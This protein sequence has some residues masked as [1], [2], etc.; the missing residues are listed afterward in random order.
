MS[1]RGGLLSVSFRCSGTHS[2]RKT[3][4]TLS[5]KKRK[6]TPQTQ[7]GRRAGKV[8]EQQH[9]ER[10]RRRRQHTAH[11][12]LRAD[13]E[14]ELRGGQRKPC[15]GSALLFLRGRRIRLSV[16]AQVGHKKETAFSI[17][18][19][20]R[21]S[22]SALGVEA[23][24]PQRTAPAA[25]A[26]E[27]RAA[28]GT[29]TPVFGRHGPRLVSPATATHRRSSFDAHP[30]PHKT[31]GVLDNTDSDRGE[32]LRTDTLSA[33]ARR[34]ASPGCSKLSGG[35]ARACRSPRCWRCRRR[36]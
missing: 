10:R 34:R 7:V 16:S 31:T 14:A 27:P 8:V 20:R 15:E 30:S 4:Q 3:P 23:A 13:E 32:R 35:S 19:P 6:E 22:G 28:A 9:R 33:R 12:K 21:G 17:S 26:A 25:A 1:A 5:E 18:R 2:A 36:E 29:R 24:H 11:Q